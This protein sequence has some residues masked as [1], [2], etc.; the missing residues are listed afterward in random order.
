MAWRDVV[1]PT[2]HQRNS[3]RRLVTEHLSERFQT[4]TYSSNK[5]SSPANSPVR[6]TEKKTY[7]TFTDI[8]SLPTDPQLVDS[9]SAS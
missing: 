4:L 6:H 3:L 7:L 1:K 2:A 5:N 8:P 9:K